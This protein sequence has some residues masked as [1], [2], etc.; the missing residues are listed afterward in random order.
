VDALLCNVQTGSQESQASRSR[1]L[2]VR[3]GVVATG[4]I[5]IEC[6]LPR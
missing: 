6:Y 5:V 1:S 2:R 4:A 3:L